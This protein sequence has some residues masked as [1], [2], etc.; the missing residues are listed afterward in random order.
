MDNKV[1]DLFEKIINKNRYVILRNFLEIHKNEILKA[2]NNKASY[3]D[4]YETFR[5]ISN[6]Q[7]DY[8]RF[9]QILSEFKTKHIY[10]I[11]PKEKIEI[12]EKPKIIATKIIEENK[13]TQPQEEIKANNNPISDAPPSNTNENEP[14]KLSRKEK[15][16][17]LRNRPDEDKIIDVQKNQDKFVWKPS[18]KK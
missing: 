11:T 1:D 14:K 16:L 12:Q 18:I 8:V 4:I 3:K 15:L 17:A 2:L 10:N 7:I 5:E 13:P 9:C 6:I